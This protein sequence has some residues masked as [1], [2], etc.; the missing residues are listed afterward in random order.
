MILRILGVCLGL[1]MAAQAAADT[2]DINL[3]NKALR[4]TYARPVGDSQGLNMD[5]GL[6]Y[7]RKYSDNGYVLHGGLQVAGMNWSEQGD[8][9]ISLGGRA[10][11]VDI[12]S[13]DGGHVAFGGNVRFSPIYRVGFNAALYYAPE[14]TSFMDADSYTEW[15]LSA[16]YQ[17]VEQAFVYVGYREVKVGVDKGG[18][19]KLDNRAHV[20][21]RMNF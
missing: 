16:D 8:F 7:S 6:L 4:A 19:F 20:G 11:Y 15:S 5:V 13:F 18:S 17:V 2:L 14:I 21:V 12:G 3:H 10:V 9:S 1:A